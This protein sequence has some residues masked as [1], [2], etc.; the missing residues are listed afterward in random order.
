MQLSWILHPSL[1]IICPQSPLSD[2][3]GPIYTSFPMI[4]LPIIVAS[5]SIKDEGSITGLYPIIRK[6][7]YTLSIIVA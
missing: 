3:P 6:S 7:Y 2:A 4:T 5:L 1:T